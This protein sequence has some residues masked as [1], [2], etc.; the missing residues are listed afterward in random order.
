MS[1]PRTLSGAMIAVTATAPA[2]DDSAGYVGI[3]DWAAGEFCPNVYPVIKRAFAT[4]E[5]KTTCPGINVDIKSSSKYEPVVFAMDPS[6]NTVAEGILQ[7]AADSLVDFVY[8]RFT[9]PLR[10][11]EA[12]NQAFY[13]KVQV[14]DFCETKG[15]DED[16]IDWREA[17]ML[18]QREL[19]KVAAT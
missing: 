3:A 7:T 6:D 12:T 9:M 19:I 14:Q 17:T 13:T 18:I 2:T 11:G 10:E 16:E 8:V 5:K 4:V 1:G 15:G